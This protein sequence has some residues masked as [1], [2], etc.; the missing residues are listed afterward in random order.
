MEESE[1]F[2]VEFA[3]DEVGEVADLHRNL[4]KRTDDEAENAPRVVGSHLC[5]DGPSCVHMRAEFC[6]ELLVVIFV[7]FSARFWTDSP[8]AVGGDSE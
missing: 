1:V 7:Y 8:K 2:G 4:T 5:L 6:V 3:S